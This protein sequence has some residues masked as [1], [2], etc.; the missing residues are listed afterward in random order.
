MSAALKILIQEE[1]KLI[2]TPEVW[3]KANEILGDPRSSNKDVVKV[4][5]NDPALTAYIL[6]VV[7]GDSYDFPQKIDTVSRAVSVIGKS[8]LFKM[9]TAVSAERVFD[10][11]PNNMVSPLTFWK[12]SMACGLA[13][14]AIAKKCNILHAERLLIAGT[15]HD[16]GSL[17]I[18]SKM[19]SKAAEAL[20][21]ADGDEE[22]LC[23]VEQEIFGFTHA[24]VGAE[25]IRSWGLPE[26]IAAA[27]EH[28]HDPEAGNNAC[29]EPSIVH[30]ANI[31]ASRL[32][33]ANFVEWSSRET[34]EPDPIALDITGL[35][36]KD[37][38][39]ISTSVEFEIEQTTDLF[40]EKRHIM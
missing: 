18:Y 24:K 35:T 2:L 1:F 38:E 33:D 34:P 4:M 39:N 30:L 22:V 9:V 6:K 13:S 21:A 32:Q 29:L 16:I 15:L 40:P 25:I 11:I 3:I 10:G 20:I 5:S 7:N 36:P 14:K 8:D 28:H 26:S 17:I 23:A 37:I 31:I 19:P 12:H 27:V